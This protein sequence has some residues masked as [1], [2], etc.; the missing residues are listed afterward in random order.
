[1]R[2]SISNAEIKNEAGIGNNLRSS[3][4]V[5][6]DGTVKTI[7]GRMMSFPTDGYAFVIATGNFWVLHERGTHDLLKFGVSDKVGVFPVDQENEILIPSDWQG[8]TYRD[9][10]SIHGFF[11]VKTGVKTFYFL[12]QKITGHTSTIHDANLTILFFPTS[13][14]VVFGSSSPGEDPPDLTPAQIEAV[15]AEQVKAETEA[16]R[17]EFETKLA[18][19]REEMEKQLGELNEKEINDK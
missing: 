11:E 16:V 13:Y 14:G 17:A 1:M 3:G 2:R 15:I 7:L 19:I 18:E 4:T 5:T 6:L 12:G 9:I 10:L 8:M